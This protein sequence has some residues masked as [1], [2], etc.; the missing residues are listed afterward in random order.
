MEDCINYQGSN[1]VIQ[2]AKKKNIEQNAIVTLF[3]NVK[4]LVLRLKKSH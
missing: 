1:K 4:D 2:K 3:E